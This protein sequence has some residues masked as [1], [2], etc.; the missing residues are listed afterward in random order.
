MFYLEKKMMIDN[1]NDILIENQKEI[2]KSVN[3]L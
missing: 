3:Q 1:A 2:F